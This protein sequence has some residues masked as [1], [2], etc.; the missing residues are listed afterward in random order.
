MII[1]KMT[2]KIEKMI[3]MGSPRLFGTLEYRNLLNKQ[4][5]LCSFG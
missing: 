2:N 1:I 5:L 3:K 4:F